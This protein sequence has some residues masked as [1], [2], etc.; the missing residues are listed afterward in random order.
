MIFLRNIQNLYY[1]NEIF[2]IKRYYDKNI[3]FIEYLENKSMISAR[4]Q[5]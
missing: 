2:E 1:K 3:K 4:K 5:K